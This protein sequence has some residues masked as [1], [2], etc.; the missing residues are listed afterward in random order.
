MAR[1]DERASGGGGDSEFDGWSC[2]LSGLR[3]WRGSIDFGYQLEDYDA[4]GSQPSQSSVSFDLI[5]NHKL[6]VTQYPSTTISLETIF[7]IR[8]TRISVSPDFDLPSNLIIL[9]ERQA[10]PSMTS[11]RNLAGLFRDTGHADTGRTTQQLTCARLWLSQGL[12]A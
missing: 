3:G 8:S 7:C 12:C 2:E 4:L 10:L 1:R 9:I 5:L 11:L 6:L